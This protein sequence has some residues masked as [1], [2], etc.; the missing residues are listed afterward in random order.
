MQIW[1][2]NRG[3]GHGVPVVFRSGNVYLVDVERAHA[4][5]LAQ[6]GMG[7]RLPGGGP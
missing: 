2:M 5:L 6:L 1:Y 3:Q 4:G 7:M